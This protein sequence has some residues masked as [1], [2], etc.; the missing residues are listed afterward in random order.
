[1]NL[2]TP[3]GRLRLLSLIEG[4]SFVLLLFVAMPLKYFAGQPE[5]VRLVGMAHGILFL[6]AVAAAGQAHLAYRWPVKRT[7]LIMLATLIP[8]GPFV[9]DRRIL[10]KLDGNE[11]PETA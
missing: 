2:R 10:S 5:A 9:A 7:A 11:M 8:F 6:L 4:W 3:L 1:M